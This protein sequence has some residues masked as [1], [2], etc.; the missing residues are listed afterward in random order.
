[1]HNFI[2]SKDIEEGPNFKRNYDHKR[3][4]IVIR[5]L[6]VVS[7]APSRVYINYLALPIPKT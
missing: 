5:L 3:P 1:M 2:L 6:V 7:I 4:F